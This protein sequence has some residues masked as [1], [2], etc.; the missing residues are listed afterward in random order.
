VN[1][2]RDP[3]GKEERKG[4]VRKDASLNLNLQTAV[5]EEKMGS[6]MPD[7]QKGKEGT[8]KSS[9]TEKE[10]TRHAS[11]TM[12]PGGKRE[13]K[14]K[15]PCGRVDHQGERGGGG[16]KRG[17]LSIVCPRKRKAFIFREHQ[18]RGGKKKREGGKRNVFQSAAGGQKKLPFRAP[19]GEKGGE[20]GERA[21]IA[22]LSQK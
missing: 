7:V 17:S 22:R 15:F 3:K 2:A 1:P 19:A 11:S 9:V 6:V 8:E 5:R 21:R 20:K 16:G 4:G 13:K 14:K 18:E 12:R 10:K